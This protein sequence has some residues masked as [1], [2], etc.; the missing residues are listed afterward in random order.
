METLDIVIIVAISIILINI[1]VI[2]M[3]KFSFQNEEYFNNTNE[4]QIQIIP[5]FSELSQTNAQ[6]VKFP[7]DEHIIDYGNYVCMKRSEYDKM[8]SNKIINDV[9]QYNKK[10]VDKVIDNDKYN[11]DDNYDTDDYVSENS[12][13]MSP[14]YENEFI[15]GANIESYYSYGKINDIGQFN[16]TNMPFKYPKPANFL[17]APL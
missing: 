6:H 8:H 16:V 13:M 12:K 14:S 4:E 5:D 2:N 9:A 7:N 10:Q 15:K 1:I 17:F 11:N 3:N